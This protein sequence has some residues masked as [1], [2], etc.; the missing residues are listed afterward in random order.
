MTEQAKKV[1]DLLSLASKDDMLHL[2]RRPSIQQISKELIN[3]E[4]YIRDGT[5]HGR[6]INMAEL[7]ENEG[8][9][10]GYNSFTIMQ[11]A[12]ATP[13]ER[14]NI[15]MGDDLNYFY[16]KKLFVHPEFRDQGIGTE[17]IANGLGLAKKLGKHSIIDVQK[18][19]Y[20]MMNVLEKN[21]FYSDFNW[22]TPKGVKMTRFFH[23]NF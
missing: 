7:Y 18:D 20:L 11:N 13:Y 19:N 15:D 12:K 16:F 9:V 1:K 5:L 22:V 3:Y 4:Q 14:D 8:D 10:I 17:M 6:K 23:E 2:I 21:N